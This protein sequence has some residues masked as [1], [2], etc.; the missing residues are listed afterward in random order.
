MRQRQTGQ[1]Q[2]RL[3]LSLSDMGTPLLEVAAVHLLK[4]IVLFGISEISTNKQYSVPL[5]IV[6]APYFELLY[7]I[8]QG[9]FE[10]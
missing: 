7:C 10:E 6:A 5:R 3:Y 4:R 2:S 8:M 9:G 1:R